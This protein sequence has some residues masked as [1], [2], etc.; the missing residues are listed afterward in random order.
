MAATDQQVQTFVNARI[1]PH[2][3]LLRKLLLAFEDD[4]TAIDDV[5]AALNMPSPTWSDDRPDGPPHL[6]TPSDVLAFNTFMADIITAI[7]SNAQLPVVLKACV[8]AV[9]A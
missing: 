8:R 9:E 7:R 5:Y 3:E 6:L 1:R 2:A 4:R